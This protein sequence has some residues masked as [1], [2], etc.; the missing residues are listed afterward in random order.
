MLLPLLSHLPQYFF[1]FLMFKIKIKN[2]LYPNLYPMAFVALASVDKAPA[3]L[4]LPS[5]NGST[6]AMEMSLS[7]QL[8]GEQRW[9]A[10][11]G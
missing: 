9:V 2:A 7:L 3:A 8:A 5:L 10:S 1:Q 4:G 6:E 11:Q